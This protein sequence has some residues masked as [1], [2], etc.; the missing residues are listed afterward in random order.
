[1]VCLSFCVV[2]FLG[3][4]A[5]MQ[6]PS[7]EQIVAVTS[8]N[9]KPNNESV[10]VQSTT[11]ERVNAPAQEPQAALLPID[12]NKA[13]PIPANSAVSTGTAA[14]GVKN[15]NRF[16]AKTA[17][18]DNVA[19]LS[20]DT[21]QEG[22]SV[23]DPG[24]EPFVINMEDAALY[25][26]ILFLAKQLDLNC[27]IESEIR[28]KITIR[29]TGKLN[30]N[31][32]LPLFFQ[33]LEANGLT[34]VKEGNFYKIIAVANVSRNVL[35]VTSMGDD[36]L[37][38]SPGMLLQIIPLQYIN[39]EE[40]VKILTPFISEGGSLLSHDGSKI[41]L[42][43]DSS[44]N[45]EKVLKLV[46]TFDV[47]MFASISHRIFK[48]EH[49]SSTTIASTIS[50]ILSSYEDKNSK[51]K[52]INLD[53][54]NSLLVLSDS[55][56][57][58]GKVSE[59]LLELDKA[60]TGVE[61]QLFLYFLK[62]SQA[63]E[64]AG[65]LNSIFTKNKSDEVQNDKNTDSRA[66][67]D[68]IAET[69]DKK[70]SPFPTEKKDKPIKVSRQTS[71]SDFGAGA[72]RGEIK[73]VQDKIRNALIIDAIPADYQAVEKVLKRLDILPK[74]VLISVNIVDVQLDD[75]LKLGVEYNYHHS[76]TETT[77]ALNSFFNIATGSSG[78]GYS[79]GQT[80]KWDATLSA[81]AQKKKV[82]IVATPTIL[83]SNNVAASIDIS[84]EI[85]VA[86]AQITTDSEV[87]TTSN[88]TQ[89]N[90]QY[91][92]TGIILNVTPHINEY[93]LVSMDL[94]QEVSEQS[95]AVAVGNASYPSFFKRSVKTTLTVNSNQSIAIGGLIRHQKSKT[96]SGVP[97]LVDLPLIGWLF[98]T[99]GT[100]EAK[101]ELIIVITPRVVSTPDDID[102][103]TADFTK[104]LG[105]ML[106]K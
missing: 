98:G 19:R 64:M 3:G 63:E 9:I 103:I 28:G 49:V 42:L 17:K 36:G 80:L 2:L 11:P 34:A 56:S 97:F 45:V 4:C 54:L 61:S 66:I 57:I 92:N 90:I 67:K 52:I 79:I 68:S 43:V 86:S 37:V 47:D 78:L 41:L 91:R 88:R 93:G 15:P 99:Q 101:S 29:T 84:T 46:R 13:Q 40:M 85:P 75:D 23:T 33:I 82:D 5:A 25:D 96:S 81:L 12:I 24:A 65:L 38:K 16:A 31:D 89:T 55:Q 27:I 18:A 50:E 39:S 59:L 83:A 69:K 14:K 77:T 60:N 21:N 76:N 35:P 30:R 53:K 100:S 72:L 1:M 71:S 7:N 104:N 73:I 95:S 26:V 74:Q 102:A 20:P 32:L 10:A 8:S 44:R 87:T 62:N 70:L 6:S 105:Y 51:T 48:I 22:S 58:F 106:K 94:S